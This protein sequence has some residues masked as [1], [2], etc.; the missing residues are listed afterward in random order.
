MAMTFDVGIIGA[1]FSITIIDT[2]DMPK[3]KKT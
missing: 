1:V 2:P 3:K